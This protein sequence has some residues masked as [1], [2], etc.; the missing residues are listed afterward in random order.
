MA[1]NRLMTKVRINELRATQGLPLAP[2]RCALCGAASES[3][4]HLFTVCAAAE[5]LWQAAK[6]RWSKFHESV[7]PDGRQLRLVG[8][9]S[10]VISN[11]EWFD[12]SACV[13]HYIWLLR[14]LVVH[15]ELAAMTDG[16]RVERMNT[17]VATINLVM[18][19][20]K[21][22]RSRS[23]GEPEAAEVPRS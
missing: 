3:A 17:M 10:E 6:E 15:A 4:E 19:R 8:M 14:N 2:D 13:R 1:H 18:A 22:R 11:V 16:M 12:V 5:P 9:D 23:G 21:R 20:Y 7:V